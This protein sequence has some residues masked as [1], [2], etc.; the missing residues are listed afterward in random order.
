VGTLAVRILGPLEVARDGREVIVSGLRRRALLVRLAVSANEVVPS[1]R[2]IEDLWDGAPPPGAASTLQSHVSVLRGLIGSDRIRF[3]DGGY[4]LLLHD[5]ECD[6]GSVDELTEAR[7]AERAG[8]LELAAV[9]LEQWLAR[10][11]GD[12]LADVAGA[13][14]AVGEVSRLE[15]LRAGAVEQWLGVRLALGDHGTVVA[16]AERAVSEF[17]LREGFWSALMLALYRSGRQSDALRSY[18]RLRNVLGEELGIEPSTELRDL[19]EAMLLQNP[20]LDWRPPIG[21]PDS[22][23]SKAFPMGT[24]TFLL[25]DI[26][27]S[28]ALLEFVGDEVFEQLLQEHHRVV[29]EA[30]AVHSGIEVSADDSGFFVVFSDA[31]DAL[32]MATDTQTALCGLGDSDNVQVRVRMGLHTGTGRRVGGTYAG[33]AVRQAS[34]VCQAGHGGQIVATQATRAAAGGLTDGMRW[35]ALGRHRLQG[36]SLPLE[37]HQLCHPGLEE[38]FEALHSLGAFTHHLPVQV[39]S[40]LG[41]VEELVLGA[42]LLAANR[43]LTVVGPGGSGKTRIAYRLAEAQL[44]QFPDGV[45]A[46]ELASESDPQ[47]IPALLL[48]RLGLRDEP[49]RTATESIV[50]HLQDSRALVVLDNCEHLVDA[51]ASF[52]AELLRSCEKLRVLVTSREALRIEGETVW[53][54]G[55]LQLP[56]VGEL[57]LGEIAGSD[58]VALFCER[59]GE[60]LAG[61]SLDTSN[62]ATVTTI[63]RRMEGMPLTIELA[64][65]W[66]RTLPLT[67]IAQR[68]ENS[69]DLLSKGSRRGGDRHASLRATLAWSHDLLDP[70]EQVLFR[71]L[72]VFFGGFTLAAA[73]RMGPGEG[74]DVTEVLDA[75]DG[76]V[77]KS[78]VVLSIDQAG[79]GRYR[80]LETVRAYAHERL[81]AA[82]ELAVQMNRHAEF[83][84]Q[85]AADCDADVVSGANN[86]RMEAD[87]PNLLAALEYLAGSDQPNEYGQL[88]VHLAQFWNVRGYWRLGDVELRRFLAQDASDC[89]FHAAGLRLLGNV[90]ARMGDYPE[91][92]AGYEE[93]LVTARQ[94]GDRWEEATDLAGL[95]QVAWYLADYS[96][97]RARYEEA[98]AIAQELGD[99]QMEA[100]WLLNI[101]MV[102]HW[103]A[104]YTEARSN[105][106]Q[107]LMIARNVG[108]RLQEAHSLGSMGVTS[109]AMGDDHEALARYEEALAIFREI[110]SPGHEAGYIGNIGR[111]HLRFGNYP[112]CRSRFEEALTITRELGDRQSEG[113][114]IGSLGQLASQVDDYNEA[115]NRF[116]EALTI[117]RELG[118]RRSQRDWLNELGVLECTVGQHAEALYHYQ[119]AIVIARELR[120]PDDRLL[121]SCAE[122][123]VALERFEHATELLG[124]AD[125]IT[126]QTR[127]HRTAS[128]QSRYD[129]SL[130]ACR[131][132]QSEQAFELAFE[133]GNASD[134]ECASERASEL[135]GLD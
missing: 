20:E 47:R 123:L 66:V 39:S 108:D 107:A 38:D 129:A 110:G 122:L 87:H 22:A 23:E 119:E 55:P 33:L 124:A 84:S 13:S 58:A 114:W 81:E 75:L 116:A 76:L 70:T 99:R 73:E 89:A 11:R 68:L 16:D 52:A 31:G 44:N 54:L 2:L 6:V 46:V 28:T 41:R 126:T 96:E 24:V 32:A 78:L 45:W 130:E 51:A 67:Q 102:D 21:T 72:A 131:A 132:H 8:D 115:R 61:F 112:E 27:S 62:A 88:V 86:D 74:L 98:L 4:T 9:L 90:A 25:T 77:D 37:L 42:K 36:L 64:A 135:L 63:C 53:R 57:N 35:Q 82:G 48:S 104:D 100:K 101:G 7:Q 14:W 29:R 113:Y 117:A 71:R 118:D 30:I 12:A 56:D 134:W 34:L 95:G 10:W 94:L 49:G 26:E 120:R 1:G 109:S 121:D 69:L 3:G 59:A 125:A 103:L 15:E 83:Y 79:Q 111:V 133:S 91:A 19:E 106:E 97:S 50:S 43:L 105:Y 127:G 17:P 18:T 40:F 85:L 5:G 128:E 80:L 60:S 65:A 92:Q 93:A